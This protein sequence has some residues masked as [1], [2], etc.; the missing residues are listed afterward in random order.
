MQCIDVMSASR[1]EKEEQEEGRKEAE[2][3]LL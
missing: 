1:R 3:H 2:A